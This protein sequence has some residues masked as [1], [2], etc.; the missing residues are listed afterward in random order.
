[1]R[2]ISRIDSSEGKVGEM[3]LIADD[4]ELNH[5]CI[6]ELSN[7]NRCWASDEEEAD[8]V[9]K[10]DVLARLSGTMSL[11]ASNYKG[12]GTIQGSDD[13]KD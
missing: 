6:E 7:A 11:R 3:W 4:N 9:E 8:W 13:S 12:Q 5:D 10:Y 2:N 1:M